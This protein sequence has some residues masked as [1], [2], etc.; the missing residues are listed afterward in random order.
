MLTVS[1]TE[2]DQVCTIVLSGELTDE[3]DF[4]AKMGEAPTQKDLIVKSKLLNRLNSMGIRAWLK[5]FRAA[6]T[7]GNKIRFQ[8][9]SPEV[10]EQMNLF[11]N[12]NCGG[13]IES[14]W[15]PFLC[16][17]C[18]AEPRALFTAEELKKIAPQI[19]PIKCSK[20]GSEAKFDDI[21]EGYFK[22]LKRG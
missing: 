22:F 21:L 13:S 17:K 16:V 2:T 4:A 3:H 20:C 1:R 18:H 10:V 9:C 19:S 8:D 14:V 6:Q 7:Q 15:L 12:F 11:H 5:F